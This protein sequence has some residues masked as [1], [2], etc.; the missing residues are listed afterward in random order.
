LAYNGIKR[1]RTL[2]ISWINIVLINCAIR[3]RMASIHILLSEYVLG[4]RP[5]SIM[6]LFLRSRRGFGAESLAVMTAWKE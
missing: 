5:C 4:N 6:Y 1:Y 2:G 3:V